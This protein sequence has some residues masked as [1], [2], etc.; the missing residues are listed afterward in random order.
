MTSAWAFPFRFLE[1]CLILI[2]LAVLTVACQTAEIER[3][4]YT[5]EEIKEEGLRHE[6]ARVQERIDVVARINDIG[7]PIL[8]SATDLCGPEWVALDD[9][10][11][12]FSRESFG[13]DN[14]DVA[15]EGFGMTTYRPQVRY[16]IKD[17]PGSRAG[18]KA[19]DQ[20]IMYQGIPVT[21]EKG[22]LDA[23]T[24]AL[25]DRGAVTTRAFAYKF[26]RNNRE[27]STDIVVEEV[28]DYAI[29]VSDEPTINAFA[30]DESVYFTKSIMTLMDDSQ[31]AVIFGHE[32]AHIIMSHNEKHSANQVPAQIA[33]M[34]ADIMLALLGV[35]TQGTFTE[36]ASNAARMQ[37]SADFEAEADV[38]G[39]Y[40]LARAGYPYQDAGEL[41][42]KMSANSEDNDAIYEETSHPPNAERYLILRDT[43]EEI[44]KLK[45]EN[46]PLTP[47]LPETWTPKPRPE[48][49]ADTGAVDRDDRP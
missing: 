9:G 5:E 43:A 48:L 29:Y 39:M 8:R 49:V 34:T 32:T 46:K 27:F 23:L 47:P 15:V 42:R 2:L 20:L 18:V 10:I 45:L 33:G 25:T 28:C 1:R 35:N 36:M 19:G 12:L 31:L 14:Q 40:L 37:F 16:V 24:K 26:R 4:S 7:Y 38:V 44:T 3:R 13:E 17:S 22:S 21:D 11:R 30:D 41:W 6:I